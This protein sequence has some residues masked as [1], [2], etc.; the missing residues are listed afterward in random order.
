MAPSGACRSR[1]AGRHHNKNRT[2]SH[3]ASY[4]V[5]SRV[6]GTTSR[7]VFANCLP[8]IG[9]DRYAVYPQS[10][11]VRRSA[12][13]VGMRYVPEA[14]EKL[15]KHAVARHHH[16]ISP[17]KSLVASLSSQESLTVTS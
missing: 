5:T 7:T 10:N 9:L 8:S 11:A 6:A 12:E 14:A 4:L 15:S 1:P 2:V 17:E 3:A 16:R 13:T